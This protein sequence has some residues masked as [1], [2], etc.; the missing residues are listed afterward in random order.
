MTR[1][2][3]ILILF[4]PPTTKLTNGHKMMEKATHISIDRIAS[5]QKSTD[6]K[7]KFLRT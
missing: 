6:Q 5:I 3:I 1:K 4:E 7:L 2:Y